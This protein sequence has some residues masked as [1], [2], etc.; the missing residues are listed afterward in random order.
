M[1]MRHKTIDKQLCQTRK[2]HDCDPFV[3]TLLFHLR[4]GKHSQSLYIRHPP[5]PFVF[6]H[7]DDN[8]HWALLE[9]LCF[10]FQFF[11]NPRQTNEEDSHKILD[12]FVELGGN[13]LDTANLYTSGKSEEIIGTWLKK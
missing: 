3:T 11:S 12:R 8:A 1:P 7:Y 2:K 6:R 4:S 10:P 13:F 9:H 5:H